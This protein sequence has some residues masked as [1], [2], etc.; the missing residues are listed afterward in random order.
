MFSVC[1]A[2]EDKRDGSCFSLFPC[3]NCPLCC[4]EST[5]F[6]KDENIAEQ[7]SNKI[8]TT[9]PP[10]FFFNYRFIFTQIA[11]SNVLTLNV[12]ITPKAPPLKYSESGISHIKTDASLTL[13]RG[14]GV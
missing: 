5:F 4:G 1:S 13:S 7:G 9:A 10:P 3:H 2:A 14:N 11:N 6:N 8:K 12:A